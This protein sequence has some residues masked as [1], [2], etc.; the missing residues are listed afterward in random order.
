MQRVT[1]EMVL[2]LIAPKIL[3]KRARPGRPAIPAEKQLLITLWI[4]GTPD[5]YRSVSD[6]FNASAIYCVRNVV[7]ILN[8]LSNQFITWPTNEGM[9]TSAAAFKAVSGFPGVI[10]AIDGTHISITAPKEHSESYVN[11]KGVHSIQLQVC[12]LFIETTFK[13]CF[14]GTFQKIYGL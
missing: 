8:Q 10:G 13:L 14:T 3:V 5:S 4:L 7:G 9:I 12:F 1:F 6:R 11:R 2:K